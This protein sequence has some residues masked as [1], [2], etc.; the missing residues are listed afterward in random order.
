MRKIIFLIL[1]NSI[2]CFCTSNRDNF[3]QAE[4]IVYLEPQ[5][6]IKSIERGSD[7]LS[8]LN[9]I[10]LK[11][12]E[13]FLIGNVDKIVRC[14]SFFYLLDKKQ[15]KA[16][17]KYDRD[18][19]PIKKFLQIGGSGNE[20]VE[21]IDFDINTTNKEIVLFCLPPKLLYMDLDFNVKKNKSLGKDYYDRMVTWDNNIFLYN[22]QKRIVARIESENEENPQKILATKKMEGDLI[23]DSPAF[24]KVCNNLYFQSPGDDCIYQLINN[25][26]SPFLSFNFDKKEKAMELYAKKSAQDINFEDRKAYPIPY[27]KCIFGKEDIISFVYSY[28]MLYRVCTYDV[29][30]KKYFDKIISFWPLNELS[31]YNNILYSCE[32]SPDTEVFK[33]PEFDEFMK[34][35]KY[36]FKSKLNFYEEYENPIIVEQILNEKFVN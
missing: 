2:F 28:N 23:N 7:F 1:V 9:L 35:V 18:G 10:P 26:F 11:E 34:G 33:I 19:N 17:Y 31:F 16:I 21:I 12:N 15:T 3:E 24:F 4:N 32:F 22:H 25:K 13:Q 36:D 6:A 27:I 20:Y 14:D 30:Q 5:G 8:E 29:L